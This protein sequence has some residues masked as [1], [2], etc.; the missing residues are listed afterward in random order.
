M[1]IIH[2]WYKFEFLWPC[3]PYPK[4]VKTRRGMAAGTTNPNAVQQFSFPTKLRCN[5]AS[6]KIGRGSD[7][8]WQTNN[9]GHKEGEEEEECSEEKEREKGVALLHSNIAEWSKRT[10]KYCSCLFGT[11]SPMIRGP[12]IS[13]TKTKTLPNL[14][15]P[16]SSACDPIKPAFWQHIILTP[17]SFSVIFLPAPY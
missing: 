3:R 15:L 16:I 8:Q 13:C 7:R 4:F 5:L 17:S 12:T 1:G 11:N 10:I 14:R 6:G 9:G 2:K